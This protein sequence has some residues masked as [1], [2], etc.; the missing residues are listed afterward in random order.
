MWSSVDLVFTSIQIRTG[1]GNGRISCGCLEAIKKAVSLL[2][3]HQV[4]DLD[5]I[6]WL[7]VLC[8]EKGCAALAFEEVCELLI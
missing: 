4:Q 7:T 1:P 6:F 8:A 3:N 5:L 2:S